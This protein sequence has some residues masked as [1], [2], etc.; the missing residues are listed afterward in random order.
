MSFNWDNSGAAASSTWGRND[1]NKSSGKSSNSRH[2][3][4]SAMAGDERETNVPGKYSK[5]Y[6][7]SS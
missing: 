2:G 3:R 5:D 7:R 1:V 6:L 4:G